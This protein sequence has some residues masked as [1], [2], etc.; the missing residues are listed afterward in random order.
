MPVRKKNCKKNYW[1]KLYRL[2][3]WY[4]FSLSHQCENWNCILPN[5]VLLRKFQFQSLPVINTNLENNWPIWKKR[6]KAAQKKQAKKLQ[7]KLTQ[8]W[9]STFMGDHVAPSASPMLNKQLFTLSSFPFLHLHLVT[10][11]AHHLLQLPFP[12]HS[13]WMY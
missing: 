5:L 10:Y 8:V 11:L 4:P 3:Q 9:P 13:L 12:C 2:R 7:A 1:K 6:K